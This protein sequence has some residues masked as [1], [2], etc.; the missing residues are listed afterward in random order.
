LKK[1]GGIKDLDS[2]VNNGIHFNG[3]NKEWSYD[4]NGIIWNLWREP[5][6]M[7]S[8]QQKNRLPKP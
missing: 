7:A 3:I 8:S 2:I 6:K 4:G 1:S 5:K